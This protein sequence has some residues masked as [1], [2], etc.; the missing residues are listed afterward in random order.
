[1]PLAAFVAS[2]GVTN[3]VS[4]FTEESL[5]RSGIMDPRTVDLAGAGFQFAIVLGGIVLGGCAP[6]T[7]N[8]KP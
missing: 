6:Q 4:A 1:M 7:L 8:P 3:V 5:N 2:I